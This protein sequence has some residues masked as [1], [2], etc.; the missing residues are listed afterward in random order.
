MAGK[1]IIQ[2]GDCASYFFL[3]FDGEIELKF[4]FQ[5]RN[6]DDV[7]DVLRAGTIGFIYS[8][9]DESPQLYTLMAK[10]DCYMLI[11]TKQQLLEIA[12][13]NRM[14]KENL[15]LI[16]TLLNKDELPLYNDFARARNVEDDP[17]PAPSQE[18]GEMEPPT[19]TGAI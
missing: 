12:K 7:F 13:E 8:C 10:T 3:L 2:K 16:T 17:P 9:L 11:M 19:T 15:R 6:R 18:D 14:F 5:K 4:H 1:E